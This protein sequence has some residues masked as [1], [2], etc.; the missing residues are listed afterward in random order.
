MEPLRRLGEILGTARQGRSTTSKMPRVSRRETS[1]VCATCGK[2]YLATVWASGDTETSPD[3]DCPDCR[4]ARRAK[5]EAEAG[6]NHLERARQQRRLMW[7]SQS[8]LPPRFLLKTFENFERGLQPRAYDA[9]RCLERSLVL[10]SPGVYGVGKTHLVSALANLAI[11]TQDPIIDS[12]AAPGLYR[13]HPCPVLYTTE[14]KLLAQVRATYSRQSGDGGKTEE[15]IYGALERPYY[16]IIDDVGKVRPRDPSFLQSV[17]FRIIDDRYGARTKLLLTT[18]LDLGELEEHLGG[19]SA[20]R[21]R[22]MCGKSGFIKMT[23]KSYRH[24]TE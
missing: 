14:Q 10:Y 16:L 22:E 8:G 9:V 19:A 15:D 3:P 4:E 18:N 21:L 5:A 7:R 6:Q 2:E 12:R 23:G 24:V 11:Q 20:D 1:C 13:F 17:L